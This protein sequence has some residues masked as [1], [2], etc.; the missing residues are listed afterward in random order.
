MRLVEGL[1]K[2]EGKGGLKVEQQVVAWMAEWWFHL[3]KEEPLEEDWVQEE[4]W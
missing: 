3:V 1:N 2:G 4:R